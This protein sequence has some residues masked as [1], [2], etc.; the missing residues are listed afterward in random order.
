MAALGAAAGGG[1]TAQLLLAAAAAA[2]QGAGGCAAACVAAGQRFLSQSLYSSTTPHAVTSPSASGVHADAGGG[3]HTPAGGCSGVG[4]PAWARRSVQQR[5]LGPTL[6]RR[7]GRHVWASRVGILGL[8]GRAGTATLEE[9]RRQLQISFLR[10]LRAQHTLGPPPSQQA[11]SPSPHSAGGPPG[12]QPPQEQEQDPL[13]TAPN[14]LSLARAA[15][16]PF[17]AALIWYDNWPWAIAATAVS[18]V[19][20]AG[21]QGTRE[22]S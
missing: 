7:H 20:G 18:G 17:I 15:S 5:F 8:H 14:M 16:A 21:R 4:T 22:P 9:Q 12:Q 2:H 10:A 6:P 13:W 11:P 3:P 19:S 1:Q